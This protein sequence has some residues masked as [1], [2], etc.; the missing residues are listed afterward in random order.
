METVTSAQ[1]MVGL[2]AEKRVL[3]QG[4]AGGRGIIGGGDRG[5]DG[6]CGAGGK[7]GGAGGGDKGGGK[8]G[9]LVLQ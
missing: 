8:G 7:L 2:Y 1:S 4:S 5:G 6:M 3:T 9:K